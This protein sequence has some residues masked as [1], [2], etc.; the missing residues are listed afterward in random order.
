MLLAA[1]IGNSNIT[2]GIFDKDCLVE[3]CRFISDIGINYESQLAS[4]KSYNIT[5][6]AIISVVEELSDVFKQACDNIFGIES[7]VFTSKNIGLKIALDEPEKV[8]VDRLINAHAAMKKYPL[9]LIV[10]DIGTAITFDI[11]SKK[12]EFI[13]GVIMPGFNLQFQA[14]NLHTSKL[15]LIS[16]YYSPKAIGG[17]TKEAILSGVIRGTISSIE[18]LIAQCES[19]LG[20]KATVIATGGQC[21]VLSSKKINFINPIL[22][23]EGLQEVSC[24]THVNLY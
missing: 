5:D 8:G 2:I 14:L 13:G 6:C 19:E 3:T 12:G 7:K 1:D 4:L 24:E 15:P 16:E 23:L 11:V 10:I 20:E 17:N 9:P 22:T 21:N 18:G